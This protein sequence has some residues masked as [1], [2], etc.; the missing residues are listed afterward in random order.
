MN[1]P[2]A[3]PGNLEQRVI[4]LIVEHQR[5]H[6]GQV[7]IDSTFANLGIDAFDWKELLPEFEEVFDVSIP[8]DLAKYA[9]S[10]RDVATMLRKAVAPPLP[11][12]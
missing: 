3:T 5:L 6:P 12:A 7:T 11:V 4:D 8:D 2:P 9:R 10:V 1:R